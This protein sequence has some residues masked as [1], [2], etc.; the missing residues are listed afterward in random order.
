MDLLDDTDQFVP[1][2]LRDMRLEKF[3]TLVCGALLFLAIRLDLDD[4]RG[5][6]EVL[7]V[8]FPGGGTSRAGYID[9]CEDEND[10]AVRE[11]GGECGW[12]VEDG[13]ATVDE[14]EEDIRYFGY[15][16]SNT[17]RSA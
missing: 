10:P 9:F 17:M 12:V 14:D 4:G 1:E 7:E 5:R 11:V 15:A 3:T 16:P 6:V 8:D 2:A 13:T